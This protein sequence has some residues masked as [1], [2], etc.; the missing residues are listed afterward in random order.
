MSDN[1]DNT[2][3]L[4]ATNFKV[5]AFQIIKCI[6]IIFVFLLMIASVVL[7]FTA[8]HV[9]SKAEDTIALYERQQNP[10]YNQFSNITDLVPK[11]HYKDA[12]DKS[13]KFAE[14]LS[15]LLFLSLCRKVNF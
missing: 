9:I 11:E 12:I 6:V 3:N 14:Y 13:K 4:N 5:R 10:L 1:R 7:L 8:I 2:V 15:V